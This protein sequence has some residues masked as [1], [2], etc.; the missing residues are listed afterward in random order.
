MQQVEGKEN[1]L[2]ALLEISLLQRP[3]W[4]EVAELSDINAT[5]IIVAVRV[6]TDQPLP[7]GF[8]QKGENWRRREPF[9]VHMG[10]TMKVKFCLLT[11]L[12]HP[13]RNLAAMSTSIL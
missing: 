3:F 5:S 7:W 12:V 8:V 4:R 1:Q 9:S 2:Q 13:V 10:K 6:G 11:R